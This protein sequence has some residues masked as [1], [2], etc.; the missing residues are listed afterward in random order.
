MR[1]RAKGAL[2]FLFL[3][4]AAICPGLGQGRD[5]GAAMAPPERVS[6]KALRQ[7][8]AL[9]RLLTTNEGLAILGAAL[10]SHFRSADYSADCSHF[11]HSIYERAGLPYRYASSKDLYEG[12]S[13]FR[14]VTNPQVGDLAVWRGHAGV[15]VSPAEHSF[16]SVLRS[17]PGMDSYDSPYWRRRGQPRFFRYVESV[18]SGSGSVLIHTASWQPDSAEAADPTVEDSGP[19]ESEAAAEVA[20]DSGYSAQP[21]QTRSA[22]PATARS[23]IV[24]SAHPKPDQIKSA[25]L[26]TFQDSQL[27]DHEA[28]LFSTAQSVIAFENFQVKKVHTSGSKGWVEVEIDEVAS[29]AGSDAE[30]RKHSERQQWFLSRRNSTSW[31]VALPQNTV[32]LP[33]PIAVKVLAHALA[34]LTEDNPET[35]NTRQE[36]VQLARLLN[37]LLEN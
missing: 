30:M 33:Q 34:Q 35:A 29:I 24:N 31:E 16:F 18:P 8:T 19:D 1:F 6:Q 21:E 28:E 10:D 14:R 20:R 5:Q 17:G 3:C 9:P 37:G 36:K 11:V 15:V 27:S 23:L 13:E 26:Q 7:N 22:N 25:F 2:C 4:F 32:Y 12:T